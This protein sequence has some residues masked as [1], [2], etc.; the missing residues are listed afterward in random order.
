MKLN[1]TKLNKTSIWGGVGSAVFLVLLMA[2]MPFGGIASAPMDEVDSALESDAA[3][4]KADPFALPVESAGTIELEDR[5][6]TK[7]LLGMRGL[8]QKGYVEDNGDITVL[9]FDEPI[10]YVADGITWE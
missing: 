9:T 7:E 6:P 1:T 10:H 4:A 8:T 5:D 3:E 2:L